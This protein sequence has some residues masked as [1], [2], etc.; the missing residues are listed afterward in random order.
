MACP[1]QDCSFWVILK[2][3]DQYVHSDFHSLYSEQ[4][5][6]LFQGVNPATPLLCTN[7]ANRISNRLS[8]TDNIGPILLV[9]G[10]LG[11]SCICAPL[12]PA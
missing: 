3:L 4:Y 5:S 2:S 12:M 6:C 9:I 7:L 10:I 8:A 11:K 1:R